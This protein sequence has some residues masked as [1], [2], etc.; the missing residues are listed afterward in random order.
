[1]IKCV[2]IKAYFKTLFQI[3]L[4]MYIWNRIICQQKKEHQEYI[5]SEVW[6][7]DKQ[8]SA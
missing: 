1:M 3:W 5:V 7:L 4:E 6:G 8:D 2:K